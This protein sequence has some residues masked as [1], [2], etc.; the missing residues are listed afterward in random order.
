MRKAVPAKVNVVA[1]ESSGS[2]TR[3][4]VYISAMEALA[5]KCKKPDSERPYI[6][7]LKSGRQNSKDGNDKNF[8][9]IFIFEFEVCTLRRG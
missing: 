4:K 6:I 5:H 3:D 8:D 7:S 1:A 2:G 9:L